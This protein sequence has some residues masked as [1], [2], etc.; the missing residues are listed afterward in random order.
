M[1]L[2]VVSIHHDPEVFPNPQ[3]FDPSRF[4]V[5]NCAKALSK[6]ISYNQLFF[7][8]FFHFFFFYGNE[9]QVPL[10]PFSFLGFGSGQRMC[11][12]INLAKLEI[13]IFIHHLVCRYK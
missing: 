10:K 4:D 12:G 13:S 8:P 1:N 5:R 7:F 3:Q 2:D 11:P 6:F 9:M